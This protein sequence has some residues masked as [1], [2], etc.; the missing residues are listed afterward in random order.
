MLKKA[1]VLPVLFTLVSVNLLS[2]QSSNAL[3]FDRPAEHF[4]ETLV[5]GNGKAG[6]SIFG[7]VAT[8]SI[9]LNDATLWSGEPVDPN[10]SPE[11]YKNVPEI[12]EAL[13][14]ENYKLA[15]SLQTKLQGSFS[16]SYMPLGTVY[17]NFEH[18]NKPI[19]YHRQLELEKALSTVTYEVD[20]ITFIREYLI[21]HDE[22]AMVIRLKSSKKGALN[23]NIEFKSLLKYEVT[24]NESTLEVSGYAPYHVEPSYR[25]KIPNPVQFDP[26]RGTRFTSLFKIQNTD[27]ELESTDKSVALKN[28]TEAVIYISMATSFNGF[29]KNPAT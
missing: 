26:N 12:R 9:Y 18:K 5:L 24:N 20:G 29:D 3:W 17:L 10:M 22:Q 14:N 21:S 23:F 15:D 27:G 7:G 19:S 4:E 11:A 28:A 8:D 6:A 16:Q 25:G 1:F 2:A 13:K